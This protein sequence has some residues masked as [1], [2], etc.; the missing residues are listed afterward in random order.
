MSYSTANGPYLIVGGIGG[1]AQSSVGMSTAA[2]GFATASGGGNIFG[3][4]SSD[5]IGTVVGAGYITDG[6][7][8][9][10]RLGDI[11]FVRDTGQ[12]TTIG[13]SIAV[14]TSVTTS[15]TSGLGAVSLFAGTLHST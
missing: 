15:L 12:G 9:G 4:T 10:M 3:Y 5:P 6:F 14:V 2:V 13:L 1:A 7:N 11:V 8:R